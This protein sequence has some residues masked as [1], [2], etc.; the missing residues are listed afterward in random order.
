MGVSVEKGIYVKVEIPNLHPKSID[1]NKWKTFK[2]EFKT[3]VI[4]LPDFIG[5]GNGI[6]RGHGTI[7]PFQIKEYLIEKRDR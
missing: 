1:D 3:N 7:R 6:T 4:L 5:L 2:G